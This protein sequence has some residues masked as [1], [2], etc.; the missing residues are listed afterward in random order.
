M[1]FAKMFLGNQIPIT[2]A[3]GNCFRDREM[4]LRHIEGQVRRKFAEKYSWRK[5]VKSGLQRG[6]KVVLYLLSKREYAKAKRRDLDLG[7]DEFGRDVATSVFTYARLLK[8]RGVNI[9]TI[10]VLGSRAKARWSP[11]SDVDLVV[12]ADDL[13]ST[14]YERWFLVRD[15]PI[16]MGADIFAC[17]RSEFLQYLE[18]FRI[19]PL[20]AICYG[21]IVYD[22]GFW[23]KIVSRFEELENEYRLDKSKILRILAAV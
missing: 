11:G 3:G 19:L 8:I 1:L 14:P 20:D 7:I 2:M 16:N 12:I 21:K 15:S 23:S 5:P 18:E 6:L 10:L 4:I 22:D 9:H 17:S 13:P